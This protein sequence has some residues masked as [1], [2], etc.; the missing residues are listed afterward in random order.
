VLVMGTSRLVAIACVTAAA[1]CLCSISATQRASQPVVV[2]G[3]ESSEGCA[4]TATVAVREGSSLNLR[5]G[6]ATTYPV[7]TRLSAGQHV[8]ICQSLRNGWVGVVVHE[9]GPGP[10]DCRLSDTGPRARPYAG[11]CKSGWVKD[12]FLRLFA[13]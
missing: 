11:P 1:V 7:V 5:A 9:R 2:G 13:G 8:S 6:P 12:E 10:K 4:G 3:E